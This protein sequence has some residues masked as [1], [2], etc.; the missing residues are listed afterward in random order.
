MTITP[1]Q[2]DE[3]N[4]PN[5][6]AVQALE[7]TIDATL[8]DRFDSSSRSGVYVQIKGADQKVIREIKRMYSEADW[9]VEYHS[10]Q[11]DGDSLEFTP[12]RNC[13]VQR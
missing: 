11:R 4:Q 2:A 3:L 10:D 1:D 7:K 9:N 13:E 6:E 12:K 8:V 5:R